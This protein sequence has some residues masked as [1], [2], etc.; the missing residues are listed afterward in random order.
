M[1]E[2]INPTI[3]RD[4][5]NNLDRIEYLLYTRREIP[6]SF[7]NSFKPE[8]AYYLRFGYGL[9]LA[10]KFSPELS[11]SQQLN[12]RREIERWYKDS[13]PGF[14]SLSNDVDI[15]RYS[16][17]QFFQID[18][19]KNSMENSG[20]F[21][22][23]RPEVLSFMIEG[24]RSDLLQRYEHLDQICSGFLQ[25][26]PSIEPGSLRTKEDAET[27]KFIQL[28]S[29]LNKQILFTT[30]K[31][32]EIRDL[33]QT[34]ESYNKELYSDSIDRIKKIFSD[35]YLGENSSFLEERFPNFSRVKEIL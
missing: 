35:D 18:I 6:T 17:R 25:E 5:S 3:E 19:P 31:I 7:I 32:K 10:M 34:N 11:D 16:G 24:Y 9:G 23:A 2:R 13:K 30:L 8:I 22:G 21:I 20:Q 1:N 29:F 27:K 28:Y 26:H 15:S 14:T 4:N 12:L 33:L